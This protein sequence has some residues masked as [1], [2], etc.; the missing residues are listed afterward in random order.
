MTRH[1][2]TLETMRLWTFSWAFSAGILAAFTALA[3]TVLRFPR[4]PKGGHFFSCLRR[5]TSRMISLRQTQLFTL[6]IGL[7]VIGL[8]T[9]CT[10]VLVDSE[11]RDPKTGRISRH[12]H[13]EG[14]FK[15]ITLYQ[16][17]GTPQ[18][19]QECWEN[20]RTGGCYPT[21]GTCQAASI[22]LPGTTNCR[23]VQR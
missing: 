17:G 15:D 21:S 12:S 19:S 20:D 18:A 14:Q 5:F 8:M 16:S 11:T 23:A 22:Q 1:T 9:G 3:P 7:F 13:V 6:T 2:T 4:P 10:P